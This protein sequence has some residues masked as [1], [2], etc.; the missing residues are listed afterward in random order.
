MLTRID[1]QKL[2]ETGDSN[3]LAGLARTVGHY[4]ALSGPKDLPPEKLFA[5]FGFGSPGEI[6]QLCS[7]VS[8]SSPAYMYIPVFVLI[9]NC[10]VPS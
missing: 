6:L 5:S 9:G 8:T 10:V 4:L 7:A 3:Y 2:S 1:V